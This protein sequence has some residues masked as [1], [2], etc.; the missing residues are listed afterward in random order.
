MAKVRYD[1]VH[2]NSPDPLQTAEFYEKV[3]GATRDGVRDLPDGRIMV[4]LT[5]TGT[6]ILISRPIADKPYDS[7]EHFGILTDNMEETVGQLKAYGIKFRNETQVQN[8]IKYAH[9]WAPDNVLVELI[10]K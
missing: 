5:L 10:Q 2:L 9:F 1:H 3:L 6:R 7:L 4:S 8:G